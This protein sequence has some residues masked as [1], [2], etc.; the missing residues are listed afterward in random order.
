[1]KTEI[2]FHLKKYIVEQEPAK[3]TPI[4]QAVWRFVLRQLKNYLSKNAHESY[5]D[6]MKATGIS[7][8]EIPSIES[9]SAQ[10]A[11]YGWK[12]APVSGF[13]PPATFLELQALKILPIA[14]DMR[15]IEHLTYT[16]APDIVHEA[17][18]HAP[19]VAHPEFRKYLEEYAQVARKAIINRKDLDLY[20]AIRD[21]SDIKEHPNATETEKK[22]AQEKLDSISHNMGEPS[23]A[24]LLARMA[25]WT[26]EYG[27]IGHDNP[28]I[29]GAG[30]LSSA[31]EGKSAL[32]TQTKK[33]PFS[34][35]CILY[36]YDITEK[37]PQLFVAD[38]FKTLSRV[39]EEFSKTM[40]YKRGGL[41]GLEIAKNA[42]TTNTVE[43]GLKDS[44]VGAQV[45][46]RLTEIHKN[47]DH[48]AY[49]Q[50]TGPCQISYQEKEL[51]NQGITRHKD[52]FGCPVGKIKSKTTEKNNQTK[53]LWESGVELNGILVSEIK[54]DSKVLIQIYKDCKV[55]YQGKTLFDPS[56][57]E[58]D[59]VLG[60]KVV[61][62]FSGAA[63]KEAYGEFED[64][65][66]KKI[67][68]KKYS[69]QQQN[70]FNLYQKVRDL[71]KNIKSNN[72]IEKELIQILAELNKN[73]QKD[74]L[75][76]LEI[77]ELSHQLNSKP[78]W[79]SEIE[80]ALLEKSKQN[81]E[82]SHFIA[83]G[84]KLSPKLEI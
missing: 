28:K 34:M 25:W 79:T 11:K 56:W 12:A 18:G 10:L 76:K 26:T 81:E 4:D 64:F 69:D 70:L 63:D 84:L 1:M 67:P 62:V 49:L 54:K 36:S 21:L 24:S 48:A 41:Y 29:Y 8:E 6:G 44:E 77:L 13:I 7:V 3:Y 68:P 9:I 53:I 45:S 46:G 47:G 59:L 19:M 57:G 15:T 58:Y 35:D 27:L 42:E 60:E 83:E 51:E 52:G 22:S 14:S 30:L 33:I 73:H 74:W 31:G 39:L 82:V 80:D 38:S 55:T 2:P 78:S 50:F 17:A 75:L 37:Q 61:S 32:S 72:N 23:E 40:A 71:R 20:E 5:L 65:S 43:F 16:P 66:A